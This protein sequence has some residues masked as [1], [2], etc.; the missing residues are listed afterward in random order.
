MR[1][2]RKKSSAS[3][4]YLTTD[5]DD[6]DEA[7]KKRDCELVHEIELEHDFLRS[8]LLARMWKFT[9]QVDVS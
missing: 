3:D 6:R 5:I 8:T 7:C 1:V 9:T 2:K 4:V